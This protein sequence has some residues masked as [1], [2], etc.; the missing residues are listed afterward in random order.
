MRQ[1]VF[2]FKV[3][4]WNEIWWCAPLFGATECNWAFIYNY[5]EGT[6]FDTP[7]PTEGRTAGVYEQIYHFP[8]VS[9]AVINPDTGGTSMWQHE[10]GFNDISGVQPISKA[11]LASISTAEF[12]VV[13]PK[14]QGQQ[15]VDRNMSFN[16]L[17]PDFDQRGDL[18]FRV[19]SRMNARAPI[20]LK[21]E[22]VIPAI[23][24]ETQEE[25]VKFKTTG[26]LT[27]FEIVSNTL[28]GN[29]VFGAPVIHWVP[30]DGRRE[31]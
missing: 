1:K 4:R 10:F 16:L 20:R 26:R 27:T 11:I 25:L 30:G 29:F 13:I 5:T 19:Y 9:S 3:P 23:V 24:D 2:V 22:K 18:T 15:G 12:S 7:L 28:D 31:D 6:W 17:E 14:Q 21:T 8:L